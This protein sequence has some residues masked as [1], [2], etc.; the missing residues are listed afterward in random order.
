VGRVVDGIP[1]RVVQPQ[2]AALGN[3]VVPQIPELI[4]RAILSQAANEG[5]APLIERLP[6]TPSRA[7]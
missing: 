7:A 1:A 3:A 2:I 4:G 5:D 6:P